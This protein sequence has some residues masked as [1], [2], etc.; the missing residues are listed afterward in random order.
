MELEDWNPSTLVSIPVFLHVSL[1]I[2]EEVVDRTLVLFQRPYF[3]ALFLTP[4]LTCWVNLEPD[5]L[6]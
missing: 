2:Q 3:E 5:Q 6:M 1:V 4:S